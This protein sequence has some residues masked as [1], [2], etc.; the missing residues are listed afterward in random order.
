MLQNEEE[1]NV[2]V[3]QRDDTDTQCRCRRGDCAA[4]PQEEED[5]DMPSVSGTYI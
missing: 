4:C 1:S 5:D 3:E 2:D